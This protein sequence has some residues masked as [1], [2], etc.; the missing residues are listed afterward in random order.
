MDTGKL[1]SIVTEAKELGISFIIIAGGEPL[2]R[3]EILD[4]AADFPE[5]TFLVFTNGLLITDPIAERLAK[6]RNFVPVISL[7][8]QEENTDERRGSGVYHRLQITVDKL[9][10]RRIFWSSD[11]AALV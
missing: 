9:E 5:I 1:L 4:I 6:Q 11:F 3:P 2:I 8:G 10:Q 7:E